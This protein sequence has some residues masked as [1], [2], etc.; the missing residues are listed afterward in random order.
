MDEIFFP[1]K[2][3]SPRGIG[4]CFAMNADAKVAFNEV[5]DVCLDLYGKGSMRSP[6]SQRDPEYGLLMG[7]LNFLETQTNS[8]GKR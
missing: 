5:D 4:S 3:N 8:A 6:F 1:Y 7:A 2:S